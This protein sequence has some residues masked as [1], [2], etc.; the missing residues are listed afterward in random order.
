[1]RVT[2]TDRHIKLW[3]SANETY[4]WARRPGES[5]PCSQLAGK[6][7]Y[8]EFDSNGLCDMSINGRLK[9]CDA[10]EF[11]ALTSDMLRD[12]GKVPKDHP[13]YYFAVG[14]HISE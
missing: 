10:S 11:N 13:C 9:D 4:A 8:A 3:I 6:R 14:Q 2:V 7:V 1:M 12:S 5:W